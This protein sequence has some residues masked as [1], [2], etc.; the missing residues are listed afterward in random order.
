[1]TVPGLRLLEVGDE[2]VAGL[3]VDKTV[4]DDPVTVEFSV[5]DAVLT[6]EEDGKVDDVED[7]PAVLIVELIVDV[8]GSIGEVEDPGFNVV[9]V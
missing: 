1:M 7:V 2:V 9:E 4:D 5:V 3:L 8:D 6:V